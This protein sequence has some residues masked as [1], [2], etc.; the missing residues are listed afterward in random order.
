MLA[1]V[2][3]GLALLAIA[4]PFTRAQYPASRVGGLLAIAAAIEV[5]HGLRRSTIAARRQA[6]VGAVI[7][8]AIALFLINAPFVAAEGLRLL[9]AGWFGVDALRYAIAIVRRSDRRERM[10]ALL[11][12]C[13]NAAVALVVLVARE[14]GMTWVIPVAGASRIAGIAWNIMTAPVHTTTEANETVVSELGLSDSPEAAAMAAEIEASRAG[15]R[16]DRS[17]LDAGVHRDAVRDSHRP[18]AN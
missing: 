16:A 11:A 3:L 17:W 9:V 15:A 1:A 18:D 4:T 5:V 10:L 6:T 8:M 7:S 12:C 13:G 2:T 14:W